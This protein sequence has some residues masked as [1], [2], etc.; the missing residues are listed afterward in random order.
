MTHHH[1]QCVRACV[2]VRG[3]CV[4]GCACV[5]PH[6]KGVFL[7]RECMALVTRPCLAPPIQP[8]LESSGPVLEEATIDA[9]A[10]TSS[11]Q[12]G[13]TCL[14]SHTAGCLAK[15][16]Y[17]DRPLDE[18]VRHAVERL[19]DEEVACTVGSLKLYLQY[20]YGRRA[21]DKDL[22]DRLF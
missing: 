2:F 7:M 4:C 12:C 14:I 20:A 13:D 18:L 16:C 22:R 10:A 6:F 11:T 3:A 1:V 5:Y 19:Y 21:T 8:C 17:D 15:P 9:A